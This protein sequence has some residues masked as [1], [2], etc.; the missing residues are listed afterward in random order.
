MRY[1]STRPKRQF[2]AGVSCPKCHTIDSIVHIQIF[3]PEAD[4]YV[5]CV[6]C[7]YK[8]RRPSADEVQEKNQ[9]KTTDAGIKVVS[10]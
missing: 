3:V 6:H 1:Q 8:D 4:E 7:D 5:E 9:P 2:L 10:L